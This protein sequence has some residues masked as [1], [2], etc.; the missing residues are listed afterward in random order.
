MYYISEKFEMYELFAY[1]EPN[2]FLGRGYQVRL[3]GCKNKVYD[4]EFRDFK[5][6]Y[7]L[8]ERLLVGH[9]GRDADTANRIRYK[10]HPVNHVKP[11]P[12]F[13]NKDTS[14]SNSAY[15]PLVRR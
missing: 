9:Y 15:N 2:E 6:A 8:A 10:P 11:T 12:T 4:K 5:T 13:P 7:E 14:R 1:I 3:I